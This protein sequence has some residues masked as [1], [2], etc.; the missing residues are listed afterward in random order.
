MI[1]RYRRL[2][3]PGLSAHLPLGYELALVI[4]LK[5]IALVILYY[6]F[7]SPAHRPVADTAAH[8]I[9]PIDFNQPPHSPGR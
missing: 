1:S 6:L 4:A 7:F 9:G 3:P 8:L 2:L 5:V